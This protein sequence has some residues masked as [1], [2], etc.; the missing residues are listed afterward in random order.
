[1]VTLHR[2]DRRERKRGAYKKY[3]DKLKEM[4]K[5]CEVKRNWLENSSHTPR[6]KQK[7]GNT[8]EGERV[9]RRGE[10]VEGV[11]VLYLALLLYKVR[12]FYLYGNVMFGISFQGGRV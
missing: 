8:D 7:K 9:R 4:E 3:K 5:H 2:E 12:G 6:E 11:P 10:D 1:M